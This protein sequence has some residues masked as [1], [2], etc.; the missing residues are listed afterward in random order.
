MP[1]DLSQFLRVRSQELR[2]PSPWCLFLEVA[3][4]DGTFLRWVN[5]ASADARGSGP[6]KVPFDG[7]EWDSVGLTLGDVQYSQDGDH[8]SV[9]ITILDPLRTVSFFARSYG[10]LFGCR[11]RSWLIP[12]DRLAVPADAMRE[13]FVIV[14]CQPG[15][16]PDRVTFTLGQWSLFELRLPRQFYDRDSCPAR[17][18]DGRRCKYPGN[19]FTSD[20]AQDYLAGGTW[21]EKTREHGWRTQMAPRCSIFSA[22]LTTA[23]QLVMESS[24]RFLC[25][26]DDNRCGPYLYRPLEGDFDVDAIV[27]V[28]STA[29]PRW[30]AGILIQDEAPAGPVLEP[31]E[32]PP[33]APTSSWVLWGLQEDGA[34]GRRLALRL[35]VASSSTETVVALNRQ[36]LR[37]VRAGNNFSAYARAADSDAWSLLATA[38]CV[39]PARVRVGLVL[40]CDDTDGGPVRAEFDWIRFPSGGLSSCDFTLRGPNGCLAHENG[41]DFGGF[42]EMPDDA[43]IAQ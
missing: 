8:P 7:H 14:G 16:G 42:S 39:L 37:I 19:E 24:D 5:L 15:Q 35:T 31:G 41:V 12:Y 1:E 6:R 10:W 18:R 40:S 4:P 23:S 17:Y 25:W 13:R 43:A 34:G 30:L 22:D 32:T 11:V 26:Q 2:Q 9:P 20:R 3:L 36:R 27:N 38:S 21:A 28:P 29:R 33:P